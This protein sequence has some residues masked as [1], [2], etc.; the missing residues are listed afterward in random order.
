MNIRVGLAAGALSSAAAVAQPALS[1]RF[2]NGLSEITVA[3][4]TVVPVAVWATGLPAVGTQVPWTTPPGTGQSGSY[5]G[6]LSILFNLTATGGIWSN[7]EAAPGHGFPF[8]TF[9]PHPSTHQHLGINLGVGFNPPVTLPEFDLF[10]TSITV[11]TTDVHLDALQQLTSSPPQSGFEV[12]LSGIAPFPM[13]SHFITTQNGAAVIH[14]PSP[15]GG[16]MLGV[17]GLLA[18]RRRRGEERSP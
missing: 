9:A 18:T 12:G 4:G 7:G 15:A 3:P 2:N 1:I 6:F 10:Y 8:G 17:A 5:A 13:V 11:G 16:L 14:V